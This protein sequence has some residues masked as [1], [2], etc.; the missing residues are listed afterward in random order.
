M[1][2]FVFDGYLTPLSQSLLVF[3]CFYRCSAQTYSV[4]H[5]S[6]IMTGVE[7]DLKE[8]E[9]AIINLDFASSSRRDAFPSCKFAS[10]DFYGP[11]SC[12]QSLSC[13]DVM[14]LSKR[15]RL[16]F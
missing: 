12:S 6:V 13:K 5:Y 4:A 14:I 15:H 11:D 2:I 9:T 16:I 7:Y 1:R 10:H 8:G 3:F